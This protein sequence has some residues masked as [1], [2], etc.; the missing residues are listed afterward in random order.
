MAAT[1]CNTLQHTATHC[2]TLQHTVTHCNTLQ[3]GD[4]VVALEK[5]CLLKSVCV[6]MYIFLYE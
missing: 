6:R 2:N 4:K 1:H 3:Q 5:M